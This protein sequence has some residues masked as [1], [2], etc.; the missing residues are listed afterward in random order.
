MNNKLRIGV[1]GLGMG[2]GHITGFQSHPKAEVIAICD[3]DEGRL[4]ATGREFGIKKKFTDAR[5][6]FDEA[7]LDAV[8]IATP[9]KF[10]APLSIAALKSGLHVFCE[11]PMAMNT[12]EAEQMN[13]TAKSVGKN[14]MI[15]FSYR[16]NEIS[17][18]LKQQVDRGVVGDIYF[19]RTVW[20][21]RR[22]IHL[23]REWFYDKEFSGGGP[24][25][26]LGVHR[27]DLA[28]WLM[29]Y[30]EPAAI[31]GSTYNIIAKERALKMHKK[32][33][34]EDLSCAIVKFKNG[35]SLIV[36]AS[37]ELNIKEPEYMVTMLCGTKG[38]LVHQNVDGGYSFSGE[39]YTEEDGYL[40]T[41]RLDW[42]TI[43]IPS[44][45]QEFV[46]SI[47]EKRQP[48]ATG[49][50]GLKVMKILDGIY[51]SARTS[52]EVRYD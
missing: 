35:A 16:F 33:D 49:E 39:V 46:D 27:L 42:S 40:F 28:L 6:M 26:D 25:I 37:W 34:V 5:K 15:N 52:R 14:L 13:H 45:Y 41:K 30:P 3:I 32:F 24:L 44:P 23:L 47:I 50:E 21:R 29:G 4:E 10:H 9:N 1:I 48:L 12:K 20:H 22:S 51:E 36:E 8:S 19:G 38:G 17:Y 18:A 31:S 43:T 7:D 2:R 11:K